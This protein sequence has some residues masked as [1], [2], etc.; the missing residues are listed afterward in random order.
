MLDREGVNKMEFAIYIEMFIIVLLVIVITLKNNNISNLKHELEKYKNIEK[1]HN[2][3][4]R[5]AEVLWES[6]R[7]YEIFPSKFARDIDEI[8]RWG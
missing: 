3:Y 2:Y 6:Y 5:L 4:Y 1:E 7:K 8:S